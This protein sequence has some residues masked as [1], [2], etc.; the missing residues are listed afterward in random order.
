MKHRWIV[1]VTLGMLL[2]TSLAWVVLGTD[3]EIYLASDKN[4]QNR[5]TNLQEGDEVYIIVY[6]PDENIDCDVRDKFWTDIKIMDPKTGAYINWMSLPATDPEDDLVPMTIDLGWELYIEGAIPY[7]VDGTLPHRG[8][9][10]GNTAGSK[11][12]DYMEE[13]GADTGLFVSKRSFQIGARVDWDDPADH[14]HVVDNTVYPWA[15]GF[16]PTEFHGGGFGYWFG[17]ARGL[18]ITEDIVDPDD[19]EF[20]F[21]W[22]MPF[23]MWYEWRF[24]PS[25][26]PPPWL[27]PHGFEFE[28]AY[29]R[30]RFENMDTLVVMYQD[31][32]DETDVA[33]GMAKIDD[34]E[35]TLSWDQEIY[36]DANASATITVVDWD[37]NL[38]CNEVEWVPVFILINPGS[39]IPVDS[40]LLAPDRV[41]EGISPTNFCMFKTWGGVDPDDGTGVA[42]QDAIA[43]TWGS[44]P[45]DGEALRWYNIYHSGL[46]AIDLGNKQPVL[47]GAYYVQYATPVND[48]VD[49]DWLNVNYFDTENPDGFCRVS[50]YAQ[51][52]G[53]NTGVFQLNLNS[54]LDDLGFNSLRVRDVLVAYYLDPNDEDDFKL[55]P[56][57]I[58]EW[59]HSLVSFTDADRNDQEEYWLGR[60]P[61]YIQVI[62]SNAN[63]DPCC[64]EQV[65][66]HVC[67]VHNEDDYEWFILDETSSNSPVFFTNAGYELR[68]V[69]DALGI[70]ETLGTLVGLGGFQLWP[71]NW[72]LEAYNEDDI[73]V[74]YN[75]VYYADDITGMQGLG[76]ANP[77]TAMPPTID[78][79]RVANDV[80]FD[81]MHIGDT[82]V[83]DGQTVN[84]YFLDRQGNRVSGYVNSDCIFV[85]VIDP[86]QDEDQRRRERIDGWWD[87]GQN[88]PFGPLALNPF[89]CE[90]F[91]RVFWHPANWLLGDTNIFG[92]EPVLDGELPT[93][94]GPPES[95]SASP[96]IY[97]LNPRNGRWAAVDLMES[98]VASGIFRSVICIDLT[99]VYT[100]VPTLGVLPGDTVIAVYRD[101]SNHSDSAWISIK[102]GIGGGGTPPSQASSTMFVD[103]TGADVAS[104]TDVDMVYV[105]VIDPSHAGAAALLDAVEIAGITY[106]LEPLAGATSDTFITE[107]LDLILV[108]GEQITATY[109]DPT[110]PT[111]TSSDTVSIVAS[112]LDVTGFTV[113]PN[114]FEDEVTFGYEGSGVAQVFR[115]DVYNVAGDLVWRAEEENVTEVMWDG[116]GAAK[117]AYIYIITVTD[118]TES[119]TGRDVFVKK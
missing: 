3:A 73:Y 60:D 107:G 106:D 34:H 44:Y 48:D 22:M 90:G 42:I 54:I 109:T 37:E 40:V 51:E 74:R 10:P 43:P 31:Q 25:V 65:V 83:Y 72:Q 108:A 80:S 78:R 61:I 55:A 62:D 5:V 111:D 75:D 32:N 47:D 1:T 20:L 119:F 12:F 67:D 92:D 82:Q 41:G 98:G 52:T 99:S 101:P 93:Q 14:A 76:D 118:G 104:Y 63:V 70:G 105:K 69:W 77:E 33:V 58:E 50:F 30:G 113:T 94:E 9:E 59:N 79:I 24:A 87:G 18:V 2:L 57:Y 84:M 27:E 7:F 81:V 102:V 96:Q 39:W 68:P 116:A 26:L 86:D 110:D 56:A 11:L 100:C 15:E 88:W 28:F 46:P 115:V 21:P 19:L 89:V 71:D 85:E 95:V 8:H 91:E 38:N 45:M 16:H 13:T 29:V 6:D 53:V 35:A 17:A 114:P 66:V 112:V 64:P 97:V 23:V 36:K 117:G 4:G 103:E 49:L